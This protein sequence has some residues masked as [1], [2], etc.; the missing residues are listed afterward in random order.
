MVPRPV[1][2]PPR[3]PGG[4]GSA[5]GARPGRGARPPR[6]GVWRRTWAA[7]GGCRGLLRPRGGGRRVRPV[8]PGVPRAARARRLDI[9]VLMALAVSGAVA[10]GQW[11]EAATVAFLFGLSEALEALS[12][13]RARRAVRRP[14][15]K[16]RPRRPSGS[17]RTG[18]AAVVP[19]GQSARGDR[20]RVRAG[21]RVPIDGAVVAGRSSVDQKAITGESVPV[22][23]EPGRRRLRRDGQRRRVARGRGHRACGRRPDLPDHRAGPRGPGRPGAGRAPPRAVRRLV[24]ARWS[25]PLRWLVM[26][27][28]AARLARLGVARRTGSTGSRGACRAGD[29]LPVRPGDRHARRGRQRPGRRRR[30]AGSWSRGGSSSKSSAGCGCSRSTRRAP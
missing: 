4:P 28:P 21:E 26:T 11:D 29:R 6:G 19:A 2:R 12:L 20:V 14:F 25:S 24:H 16:S 27:G 1:R 18:R 22:L 10:L 23:R 30:G 17:G 5:A 3:R 15:W 8:P 13:D 7:R 9:H